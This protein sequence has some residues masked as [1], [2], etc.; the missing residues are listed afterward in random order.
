MS[1]AA[2]AAPARGKRRRSIETPSGTPTFAPIAF[3]PLSAT[4]TMP[5]P[6]VAASSPAMQPLGGQKTIRK[7]TQTIARNVS[8]MSC[9][10]RLAHAIPLERTMAML[11]AGRRLQ[12]S[13]VL[14]QCTQMHD[15]ALKCASC[16]RSV[17]TACQ[18]SCLACRGDFC[19]TCTTT[20]CV[21]T[22]GFLTP[23]TIASVM[24]SG[25][26]DSSASIATCGLRETRLEDAAL[27][28]FCRACV[29]DSAA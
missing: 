18:Q 6:P 5:V 7:D 11:L 28:S 29:S 27:S 24:M 26:S 2:A 21:S 1:D 14:G 25:S 19:A 22:P 16:K 23:L 20:K 17:C 12:Q 9:L 10:A 3:P 13:A 4:P 15:G 8:V